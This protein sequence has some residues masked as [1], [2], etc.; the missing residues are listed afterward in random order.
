MLL[1]STL[2]V[3]QQ[4]LIVFI[5][6]GVGFL[7]A[8]FGIL[9]E[10][11]ARQIT[12]FLLIIVIPCVIIMAFQTSFEPSLLKNILIAA[13]ISAL[14]HAVGILISQHLHLFNRFLQH[15]LLFSSPAAGAAGRN[16]RAL[17]LGHRR[18]FQPFRLDLR[19]P[20]DERRKRRPKMED[21]AQ[22]GDCFAPPR[23]HPGAPENPAARAR[24]DHVEVPDEFAYAFGDDSYRLPVLPLPEQL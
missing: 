12:D 10:E 18:G 24:P 6:I 17:R 14:T 13:L 23:A 4:I 21:P 11:G 9:G 22:P 16:W 20:P 19:N 7:A 15:G 1:Q 2:I 5:L 3:I 8:K